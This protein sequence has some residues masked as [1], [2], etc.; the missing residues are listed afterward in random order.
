MWVSLFLT[1]LEPRNPSLYT[2]FKIFSA[3]KVSSSEG[4][5]GRGPI[6]LSKNVCM[7]I[8]LFSSAIIVGAGI[9]NI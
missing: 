5:N 7:Y 6:D 8:F 4:V 2:N 9:S 3:R 1:L